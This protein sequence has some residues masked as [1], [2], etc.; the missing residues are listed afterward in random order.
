MPTYEESHKRYHQNE[1]FDGLGG[2]LASMLVFLDGAAGPESS[3]ASRGRREKQNRDPRAVLV[4]EG[5]CNAFVDTIKENGPGLDALASFKGMVDSLLAEGE[6]ALNRETE[7]AAENK[8][9]KPVRSRSRSRRA[10]I[11]G[12]SSRAAAPTAKQ[13]RSSSRGRRASLTRALPRQHSCGRLPGRNKSH[14]STGNS[15]VSTASISDSCSSRNSGDQKGRSRR[16]SMSGTS[17]NEVKFESDPFKDMP[18]MFDGAEYT[19]A[20]AFETNNLGVWNDQANDRDMWQVLPQRT[21]S[22]DEL[23]DYSSAHSG[24]RSSDRAKS[25]L[26]GHGA[27]ID[28]RSHT[29]RTQSTDNLSSLDSSSTHSSSHLRRSTR[30]GRQQ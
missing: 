17:S 29:R 19:D 7:S 4:A 1:G 8:Q 24:S 21:Q 2:S 13:T 26:K 27:G 12:G 10:S 3:G 6:Q 15:T 28:R 22:S 5:L 14:L 30:R 25:G 18:D 11:G 20:N 16:S 23:V 9:V